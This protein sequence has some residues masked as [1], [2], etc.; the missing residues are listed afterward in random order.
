[1]TLKEIR[2]KCNLIGKK[3]IERLE[4]KNEEI[5]REFVEH[6]D[7]FVPFLCYLGLEEFLVAKV[8]ELVLES[9][10]FV[11]GVY[12]GK[13]GICRIRLR[14]YDEWLGGLNYLLKKH[15]SYIIENAMRNFLS[16]LK[17]KL[18]HNNL[19]CSRAIIT[20]GSRKIMGI[21]LF[22]P[23]TGALIE[24]LAEI[25]CVRE[26][27]ANDN[28][29]WQKLIDNAINMAIFEKHHIFPDYYFF[30]GLSWLN[31]ISFCCNMLSRSSITRLFERHFTSVKDNSNMLYALITAHRITGAE[32]YKK[33]IKRYIIG[34]NDAF[35][36][37][38][39]VSIRK[40]PGTRYSLSVNHPLI[41]IACDA[42]HFVEN[43][44]YYINLAKS[45]AGAWI[46]RRFDTK[47][48]PKMIGLDYSSLDDQ[49]DLGISFGRL[50]ELTD[51][52]RYLDLATETIETVFDHH[53]TS[54]GMVEGVNSD[55]DIVD[56]TINPKYN[57]LSIKGY[58]FLDKIRDERIYC[59]PY[60]F[61]DLMKDR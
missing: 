22:E 4:E 46:K 56:N 36:H 2:R 29:L 52:N 13:R 7:D 33:I 23:I 47:L 14:C 32:H 50:Y 35:I 12:V 39:F 16:T 54:E 57:A 28:I 60:E 3:V 38:G 10:M 42:F 34:M 20:L 48:F 15:H 25:G 41:D 6:L 31:N 49:I 18:I 55:G 17:D 26:E 1:M 51:E 44:Q 11:N 8:E 40:S 21:P 30:G 53:Y 5:D 19:L 27:V 58:V 45:I 59:E 9:D 61:H 37:D 43:D 24:V